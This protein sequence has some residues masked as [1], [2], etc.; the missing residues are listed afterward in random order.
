MYINLIRQPLER[1]ISYFYFLR[2]GDD[3]RPHVIRKKQG[4]KMVMISKLKKDYPLFDSYLFI[5]GLCRL[6]TSVSPKEKMN[7]ILTIFGS[8][9][10]SFVGSMLIVGKHSPSSETVT[11]LTFQP[12]EF[13]HC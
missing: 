3:F 4:D 6:S 11:A 5:I 10:H 13:S 7:V 12:N 1:M 2:Y 9:F 8:R